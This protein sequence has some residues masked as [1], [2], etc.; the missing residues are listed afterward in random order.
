[1]EAPHGE[2]PL[3]T[4]DRY[5]RPVAILRIGGRVPSSATTDA[6]CMPRENPPLMIYDAATELPRNCPDSVPEDSLPMTIQP[7]HNF[8]ATGQ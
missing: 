7:H 4:A 3:V 1:M 6:A 8:P 2:D 5:G